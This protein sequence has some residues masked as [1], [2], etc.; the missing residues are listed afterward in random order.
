[1]AEAVTYTE[2]EKRRQSQLLG[3]A[4]TLSL[5]G[6]P[7]DVQT[8]RAFTRELLGSIPPSAGEDVLVV[9]NELVSNAVQH[10]VGPISLTITLEPSEV[11][12]A[13]TD[14]GPGRPSFRQPTPQDERGRGLRIVQGLTATWDVEQAADSKTITAVVRLRSRRRAAAAPVRRRSSRQ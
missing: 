6:E 12:V 9:V 3:R 5:P 8:A 10:G 1:M 13:V 14:H 2:G 4:Q 7:R 11:V